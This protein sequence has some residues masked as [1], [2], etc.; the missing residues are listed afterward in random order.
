MWKHILQKIPLFYFAILIIVTWE[1]KQRCLAWE[2]IFFYLFLHS[3]AETLSEMDYYFKSVDSNSHSLIFNV[4][5]GTT[6]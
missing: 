4:G 3:G 5:L 1:M 6:L 2:W